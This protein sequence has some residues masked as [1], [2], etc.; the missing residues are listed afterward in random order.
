[1]LFANDQ[2]L[3]DGL[4]V[5]HPAPR[6]AGRRRVAM[7]LCVASAL[8]VT[9]ALCILARARKAPQACHLAPYEPCARGGCCIPETSCVSR[10]RNA[11]QCIPTC[12]TPLWGE[13]EMGRCCPPMS[14]CTP[15]DAGFKQCVPQLVPNG[16][17]LFAR[18]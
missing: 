6:L 18:R 10:A 17:V 7:G 3:S 2:N 15:R 16:P 1:M 8:L 13:C 5:R 14:V 9:A 12:A 4:L 11:S